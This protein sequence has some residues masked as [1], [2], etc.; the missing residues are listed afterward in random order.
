MTD[1]RLLQ[2]GAES[3]GEIL[4]K[5]QATLLAKGVSITL[6]DGDGN[7][8]IEHSNGRIG[9]VTAEV[10]VDGVP[11][12]E[13]AHARPLQVIKVENSEYVLM[14]PYGAFVRSRGLTPAPAVKL[15]LAAK[16]REVPAPQI[17]VPAPAR[18]RRMALLILPALIATAAAAMAIIPEKKAAPAVEQAEE[19]SGDSPAEVAPTVIAPVPAPVAPAVVAAPAPAPA[20]TSAVALSPAEPAPQVDVTAVATNNIK[21]KKAPEDKGTGVALP[22]ARE[23]QIRDLAQSYQLEGGFDPEGAAKKLRALKKSVPANARVQRDLDRALKA[24]GN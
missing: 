13:V 24:I 7:L 5:G 9:N 11:V 17:A 1:Y 4:A 15:E 14:P 2:L 22:Q 3:R 18:K 6:A 23:R 20:P 19:E 12:Y 16:A 8:M 21:A 10:A